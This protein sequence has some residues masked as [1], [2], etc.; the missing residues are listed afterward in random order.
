MVKRSVRRRN[1]GRCCKIEGVSSEIRMQL[2]IQVDRRVNRRKVQQQRSLHF[3]PLV[4]FKL[5]RE[6]LS[7]NTTA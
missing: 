4:A 6:G 5:T 3:G 2:H 1:Q 7:P